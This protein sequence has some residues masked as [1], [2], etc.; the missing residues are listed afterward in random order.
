MIKLRIIAVG[1]DK[2][3]WVSEACAHYIKL[4]KRFAVVEVKIVPSTKA[5]PSIP[6]DQI[7]RREAERISTLMS[8]GF[9]IALANRGRKM[10]TDEFAKWL[11]AKIDTS[12]G[13]I[14]FIIGG[15]HGLHRSV[16]SQVSE[17][18]SLSPLT[19]SHQLVRLVLLEQIYRAL[20]ITHG[21]DYHK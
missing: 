13:I 4:L 15:P 2:D 11:Q 20:S 18:V 7:M 1:K 12:R 9:N 5:A 8:K 10:D 19:F 17:V 16:L 21:T 3:T 6:P 14:N